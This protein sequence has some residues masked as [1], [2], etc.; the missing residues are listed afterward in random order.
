MEGG[1][2]GEEGGVVCGEGRRARGGSAA[3]ACLAGG[4]SAS[5]RGAVHRC[6]LAYIHVCKCYL[7]FYREQMEYILD[8]TSFK[9]KGPWA[10]DPYKEVPAKVKAAFTRWGSGGAGRLGRRT[11]RQKARQQ[12]AADLLLHQEVSCNFP[13]ADAARPGEHQGSATAGRSSRLG[14]RK[15]N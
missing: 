5:Q 10:E 6:L 12:S 1:R 13:V 4:C 14:A 9:S 3:V 8:V 7:P 2:G 11:D 15:S